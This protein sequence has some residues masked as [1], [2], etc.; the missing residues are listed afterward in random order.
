MPIV[1]F[2]RDGML[3]IVYSG[4]V[5]QQEFEGQAAALEDAEVKT[6]RVPDRLVDLT[7]VTRLEITFNDMLRFANRPPDAS[8]RASQKCTRR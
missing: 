4:T 8:P 2:E 1:N 3:H 5:S 6:G 7:R